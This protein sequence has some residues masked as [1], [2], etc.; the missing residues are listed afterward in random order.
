MGKSIGVKGNRGIGL[1]LLVVLLPLVIAL[2]GFAVD[3]GIL[4]LSLQQARSTSRLMALAALQR[5]FSAQRA[6]DENP[7]QRALEAANAV[8]AATPVIGGKGTRNPIGLGEG[9]YPGGNLLPG[10][11]YYA[12]I[13][14]AQCTDPSHCVCDSSGLCNPCEIGDTPC[15]VRLEG[16]TAPISAFKVS[17]TF[18][19]SFALRFLQAIGF[20]NSFQIAAASTASAIPR[21]V[22]FLVD[23]S[24]SLT[25]DTYLRRSTYQQRDTPEQGRGSQFAFYDGDDARLCGVC[26]SSPCAPCATTDS[27]FSDLSQWRALA[28]S[29]ENFSDATIQRNGTHSIPTDSPVVHFF[30]DYESVT[31][32]T[33]PDNLLPQERVYHPEP[34]HCGSSDPET[35]PRYCSPT[36]P[37]RYKVDRFCERNGLGPNCPGPQPL[38][39]VLDG[40]RQAAQLFKNSSVAGDR[41]GMVFFDRTL[42]WSRIV[43]LTD[44]FDYFLSL[45]ARGNA[46]PTGGDADR[47]LKMKLFPG[48]DSYTD[49]LAAMV[50]GLDQLSK[51]PLRSAGVPTQDAVV[52]VTDGLA[53]CGGQPAQCNTFPDEFD[54]DHNGIINTLD[55]QHFLHCYG[56]NPIPPTCER[57]YTTVDLPQLLGAMGCSVQCRNDFAHYRQAMNALKNFIQSNVPQ[58]RVAVHVLAVGSQ[59]A[60]NLVD[61]V[62]PVSHRCLTEEEARAQRVRLVAPFELDCSDPTN[63]LECF[64]RYREA[65]AANP[66]TLAVQDLYD[67][68]RATRGSYMPLFTSLPT[69]CF[70][71]A[72]AAPNCRLENSLP[73][74]CQDGKVW[75][76]DKLCRTPPQQVNEFISSILQGRP[77]YVIVDSS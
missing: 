70:P 74:C 65:S 33:S 17:V 60:P 51:D 12:R 66:F 4:S 69:F 18:Y 63:L 58:S 37:E 15:F 73:P 7:Q 40:I 68:A 27:D 26:Q 9:T 50:E 77:P 54:F 21:H 72:G 62:D 13:Q 1:P 32:F 28:R 57:S 59:V 64:N 76:S 22:I 5:Y 71:S 2:I 49:I 39:Y 53:N 23:I 35:P 29:G 43:K 38:G 25:R 24:D 16:N 55:L 44:Q 31:P 61:K 8:S 46:V 56:V 20:G 14:Q 41:M 30:D 47:W 6:G 19:R 48:R 3:L 67:I 34:Q 11:Y 36:P 75:T 45:L 10:R 42:E 52:L